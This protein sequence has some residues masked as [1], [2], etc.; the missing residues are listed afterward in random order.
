MSIPNL[1]YTPPM[2]NKDLRNV[3]IPLDD[4]KRLRT[5]AIRLDTTPSKIINSLLHDYLH[6]ELPVSE[7]ARQLAYNMAFD[8]VAPGR[9]QEARQEKG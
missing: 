1:C 6:P 4:W 5:E 3:A 8:A 2:R 7:Q 9:G